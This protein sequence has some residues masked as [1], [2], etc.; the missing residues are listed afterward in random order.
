[1]LLRELIPFC[2]RDSCVLSL[3]GFSPPFASKGSLPPPKL[4]EDGNVHPVCLSS[5]MCAAGM[6]A[7]LLENGSAHPVCLPSSMRAADSL[8]K[9]PESRPSLVRPVC[10]SSG[11]RAGGLISRL[12]EDEFSRPVCLS[13]ILLVAGL[14]YS[15]SLPLSALRA[16]H[17]LC[18]E[19]SNEPC[20]H[21][22]SQRVR[23]GLMPG[24]PIT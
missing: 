10:L 8:A 23:P 13:S 6:I 11:M 16:L 3:S 1:M 21:T 18:S 2:M 14:W 20:A 12:L 19:V 24:A 7:K 22:G 9:L 17:S 4:L 5:C 15:S